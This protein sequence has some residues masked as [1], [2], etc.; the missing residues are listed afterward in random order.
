MTNH[1]R[2]IFFLLILAL[3]PR[4]FSL[5]TFDFIDSG[6]GS[7]SVTYISLA[8][9]LFRGE[10]YTEFGLPHTVHH[11]LL[12]DHNRPGLAGSRRPPSLRPDGIV[13]CRDSAGS[14]GISYG[15]K[16][17]RAPYRD[18]GG[19]MT[20]SFPNTGLRLNRVLLRVTIYPASD[21]RSG[22]GL[23]FVRSRRWYPAVF[24]GILLGLSFLTHPLGVVFLPPGRGIQSS[25]RIVAVA[26]L[27]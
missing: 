4:V 19:L 7:D 3:V 14:S 15:L 2:I 18:Y 22:R 9:N 25:D 5:V 16:H 20:S 23:V 11:P 8:R 17:V 13:S 1:K 26:R 6:G 27:E 10:G 21:L 12:S 24:S